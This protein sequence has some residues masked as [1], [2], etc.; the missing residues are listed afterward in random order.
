[1]RRITTAIALALIW[2]LAH[3][4]SAPAF[5]SETLTA[6]PTGS[7]PTNGG[8]IYNQRYSPLDQVN[9]SNVSQLKGVWRTRLDGSGV[10]PQYSGEA[11]PLIY[12]GVVYVVTGADDVF[13]ISIDS[14]EILW[15]YAAELDQDIST[16]CCG[17][18]SRGLG[19]GDGKIYVGQLDAKL[20]A[21]DQQTGEV[22]WSTQAE[23]WQDGFTITSAPLYYNG[24][25]ITGFAGAEFGIQAA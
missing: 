18:T 23:R 4:Q 13:A 9:Q 12:E 14:G 11:Q 21:L 25:V 6:L 19:L 22:L 2:P 5:S 20:V 17:W 24:L 3:G 8:N 10:G 7:W 16:V 1:M 15:R